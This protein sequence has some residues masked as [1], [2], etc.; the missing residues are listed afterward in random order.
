MIL[1]ESDHS[2]EEEERFYS[3]LYPLLTEARELLLSEITRIKNEEL[4][5][6]NIS[7]IEHYKARIK[8]PASAADKLK[9][10]DLPVHRDAL[11]T[12]LRDLI[13]ARIICTFLDDVY[14]TAEQLSKSPYWSVVEVKDYI[15]R[16][17]S[18]GYR[19]IHLI[20]NIPLRDASVTAEVQLR[21]IAM[22][23]WA[24]LEHQLKYKREIAHH[25]LMTRELKRCADEIASTDLTLQSIHDMVQQ[26]KEGQK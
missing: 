13:G 10:K 16:P 19:S 14:A 18:G 2:I 22:D 17:K 6:K 9:R 26:Q 8:S 11:Q 24:S 7:C 4:E 5:E 25:D 3:S 23:C 1:E 21:T 20:L 15:K 12:H